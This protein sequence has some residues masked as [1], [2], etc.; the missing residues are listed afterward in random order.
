MKAVVAALVLA[1]TSLAQ[2]DTPIERPEGI[3]VD[4]MAPPPGQAELSFDGGAP[5]GPAG[6]AEPGP[7][8]S[9][10]WALD[11]QLGYLDRP[12]R[13]HTTQVKIFPVEHRETLAL[14]GA[15]S[16][17]PAI[18]VDARLPMSHQVGDRYQGLGDDRPLDRWVLNDL[19]LGA[20]LRLSQGELFSAFVRGQVTLG[21]GND[22]QFA[23]EVHFTAAWMLIGR[24]MLP[25]GIVIAATGGV[26][27]R[28]AEVAVADR[29]LG[30]ELVGGVGATY[31]LPAIH[32]LYCD[33][34]R[35]R[36]TGEIVGVYGDDVGN[37][38]GSSPAEARI[39]LVS[40]IRPWL[41]VAARLGKGIDD[42]IGSPRFRGM[43]ELVYAGS[44][45]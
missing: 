2:A 30:D 44:E 38:K 11:V 21:T 5:V 8:H 36:I 20:R 18:I 29:V 14:G 43:L 42:Q 28:G 17:G 32:G 24:L 3:E 25:Q 9:G 27:F 7:L 12:M 26:R 37:A 19:D 39:G 23:G 6:P 15:L 45:R 41:L 10:G 16:I 13:L 22:Y 31:Q 40:E 34:N 33:A 1:A 35:V 4:R